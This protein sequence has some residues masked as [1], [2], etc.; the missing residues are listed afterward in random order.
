MHYKELFAKTMV[1]NS[2]DTVNLAGGIAWD[3][4]LEEKFR[5]L[6]FTGGIC[7]TYYM[8]EAQ[9]V[10]HG[11]KTLTSFIQIN[12]ELAAQ[13]AIH[14]RSHG[15][16][17]SMPIIALSF[18]ST[19]AEKNAFRRAFNKIILTPR[20][21]ID[22]I[23]ITKSHRGLGRAVKAC[24]ND[25]IL[26]HI[27]GGRAQFYAMKYREQLRIAIKLSHPLQESVIVDYVLGKKIELSPFPQLEAYEKFKAAEILTPEE[28]VG[29][30][31]THRLEMQTIIGVRRPTP[32]IWKAL[33]PH[34]S[35]MQLF[36]NLATLERHIGSETFSIVRE[37]L[38]VESMKYGK[39]L[40]F[41][42]IQAYEKVNDPHLKIHLENIANAYVKQYDW[43]TLGRVCIAPDISGSMSCEIALFRS[44]DPKA[45]IPMAKPS[46]IAGMFAGVLKVGIQSSLVLP[47]D[48]SA[49]LIEV[50]PNATVIQ[51]AKMLY[52][53]WGGG[54]DMSAP[55]RW[56]IQKR[57]H[58][59]TLII[60]TDS[61]EWGS[62]WLA[63]W[64]VYLSKINPR[65]RAILL[66]VDP[67]PTNPFPHAA[68]EQY[69]I[70]QIY[71]WSDVVF[72]ILLPSA[73]ITEEISG[74]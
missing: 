19:C 12:P 50:N 46:Q 17:R 44:K 4:P 59:D 72:K 33:A 63:E 62:P 71:G 24:I 51:V 36:K 45:H 28:Y 39:V 47:W 49:H 1:V 37:K 11:I 7:N 38:S 70:T 6:M 42:L 23:E 64:K 34:M 15:F 67:Y 40:P 9:M 74:E 16:M 30:I 54:T 60:I 14:G 5:Q 26:S 25:Y 65:A 27:S 3:K 73:Q 52:N 57:Q 8:N 53:E 55:V 68:A 56:L 20:D 18:L 29:L 10:R 48:T 66:R 61:E 31:K 58:I 13:H 21:L 2:A 32:E 35:T 41:R 22:F 69:N 43:S